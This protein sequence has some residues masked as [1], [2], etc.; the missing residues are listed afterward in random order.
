MS[1]SEMY[2]ALTR[3]WQSHCDA[4]IGYISS[5][6]SLSVVVDF[7]AVAGIWTICDAFK[8]H[9]CR[10]GLRRFTAHRRVAPGRLLSSSYRMA[11]IWATQWRWRC[12]EGFRAVILQLHCLRH[13]SW[14]HGVVSSAAICGDALEFSNPV[15]AF[16]PL[17]LSSYMS[18]YIDVLRSIFVSVHST[19]KTLFSGICV[20][21]KWMFS[22]EKVNADSNV[23]VLTVSVSYTSL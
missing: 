5:N 18:I 17:K 22:E 20:Q 15:W 9:A 21:C 7:V 14:M 8:I 12:C 16:F 11:R 1:L 19:Q 6:G 13:S 4:A 2:P 3:T 23:S 10:M